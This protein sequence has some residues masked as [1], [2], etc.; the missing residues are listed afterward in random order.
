MATNDAVAP[1]HVCPS[2]GI[3]V[4]DIVQPP[5]IG[6]S[7]MDDMEPQQTIVT[8]ALVRKSNAEVP[9]N[10]CWEVLSEVMVI[11]FH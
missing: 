2:I 10:A 5:G 6:I 3:Q 4:I 9:K 11:T 1:S 8:P 7:R